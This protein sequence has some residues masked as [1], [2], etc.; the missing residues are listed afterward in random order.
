MWFPG[1]ASAVSFGLVTSS[2]TATLG[3]GGWLGLTRQGLP[4]CKKRQASWRTTDRASA[5]RLDRG[6]EGKSSTDL[7]APRVGCILPDRT[8]LPSPKKPKGQPGWLRRAFGVLWRRRLFKARPYCA[9]VPHVE[10]ELHPGS[11]SRVT[12]HL[13]WVQ[14]FQHWWRRADERMSDPVQD[15]T[16]YFG[17][18]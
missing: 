10:P 9:L 17:N 16:T 4:P 15:A 11:R 13:R 2:T 12:P 5:A 1:Y 6:L 3:T 8:G 18:G 14:V 7:A